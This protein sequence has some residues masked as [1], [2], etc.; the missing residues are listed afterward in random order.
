MP[1]ANHRFAKF[2]KYGASPTEM[3]HAF[4]KDERFPMSPNL[5]E[6]HQKSDKTLKKKVN[7]DSNMSFKLRVCSAWKCQLPWLKSW[8]SLVQSSLFL[9]LVWA[10]RNFA[11]RGRLTPMVSSVSDALVPSVGCTVRWR[12]FDGM[13]RSGLSLFDGAIVPRALLE[14]NMAG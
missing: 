9:H 11:K 10:A 7:A 13:L 1:T 8:R 2:P 4:S 5:I 14:F 3:A 12:W 6:K